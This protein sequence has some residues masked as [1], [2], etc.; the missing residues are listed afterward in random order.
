MNEYK[1]WK[2]YEDPQRWTSYYEQVNE[3]LALHPETCLEIG[4]GNGYVTDVLKRTH[5]HVQTLD[6]DASLQPDYIGTVEQIPLKD[7]AVD[8]V[9]C[10]EVLEHLPYDKFESCVKEISR[11]A[12]RGAVI[13]L[14][15][16][17]Y[18]I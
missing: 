9:L 2:Q 14:P 18:T 3:V 1:S 12:K 17:G 11:V 15:H 13:S 4:V 5:V 8:V 6:I 7:H 10:A 16:W